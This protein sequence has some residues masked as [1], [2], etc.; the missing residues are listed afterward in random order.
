P[1]G[2]IYAATDRG[3]FTV[4]LTVPWKASPS[5]DLI[6]EIAK[7]FQGIDSGQSPVPASH[8]LKTGDWRLATGHGRLST[9]NRRL[10]EQFA[11]EPTIRHVHGWAVDYAE[12][13]PDKIKNWRRLAQKRAWLP[14]MDIGFDTNRDWNYSDSIFGT[15]S[16]GGSHYIAPDDKSYGQDLGWDISLSWDL[17]DLVWSSDQT[18]IDS[19]SK[20]MVELREEILDQVTRLYFE[21]RRI[22]VELLSQPDI[23]PVLV[24]DKQLRIE[25]LTALL[26]AFTEGKFSEALDSR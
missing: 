4:Q 1:D 21:R 14:S 7:R 5:R 22:Q 8:P 9:D 23:D 18:S 3:V 26:D 12:V 17:A 24:P 20:L 11:D 25:E 19:R 13:H 15:T 10:M 16:S 6:P 2:T